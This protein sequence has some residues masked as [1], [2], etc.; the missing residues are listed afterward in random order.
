MNVRK[1]R[2]YHGWGRANPIQSCVEV[3]S[4]L[5]T[6]LAGQRRR[7]TLTC[8]LAVHVGAGVCGDIPP[9]MDGKRKLERPSRTQ[10][11]AVLTSSRFEVPPARSLSSGDNP[12]SGQQR[13]DWHAP[14]TESPHE[15]AEPGWG[16]FRDDESMRSSAVENVWASVFLASRLCDAGPVQHACKSLEAAK[17]QRSHAWKRH[18]HQHR[19]SQRDTVR[20]TLGSAHKPQKAPE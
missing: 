18:L 2:E 12:V 1:I 3:V 20:A 5:D 9:R 7:D 11:K 13:S 4:K 19:N 8:R 6:C 14:S 17:N 10:S 15:G 16:N